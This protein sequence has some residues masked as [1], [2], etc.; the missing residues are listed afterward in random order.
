MDKKP[1]TRRPSPVRAAITG[2]HGSLPDYVLTNAE[3]AAMV[4]TTDSW[5]VER[6]GIQE[7][8][9]LKAPGLGTSP[10]LIPANAG[11]Q[12]RSPWLWVPAFAGTSGANCLGGRAEK[13]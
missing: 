6:P 12:G 8:R 10:P 9:I 2:V 3:L 11:I 7:R 13:V 4:D 5:L 1:E